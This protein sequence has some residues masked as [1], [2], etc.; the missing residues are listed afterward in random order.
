MLLRFRSKRGT[1]RVECLETELF[2]DVLQRWS[3]QNKVTVDLGLISIAKMDNPTEYIQAG[4]VADQTVSSLSLKHGDMLFL[5]YQELESSSEGSTEITQGSVS[6]KNAGTS[7]SK[8]VM[9]L[10]VDQEIEK[11][12]G[13]IPRSRS[14]FCKHGDKGMCEY[15]SPLPPWDRTYKQENNIKHIAFH[16]H[17]KELNEI[18]NKKSSGSSYIPPLSQPDFKVRNN[19]PSAHAPW[20]KGIC[21]KCQP[22][23]ITLQVQEFRMV[24]HVEFQKG[25]LINEFIESWRSTGLQRFGYLYGSYTHYDNTPLGIKAVIEAIW[26]PPQSNEQDGLTFDVE[27]V[28]KEL[29]HV[30]ALAEEFGLMQIGMIFTDLTDAGNGD[31]S[32]FCKRHKNSFFLSSL[33]VIMAAKQQLKHANPSRFSQQGYFSSK[34]VTCV[35]SGNLKGEIDVSAYQVSTDAEA[36]VDADM[37]SGSTHPSMAYINDTT[38]VRYVPEI[39]YMRK[40]EYNITVKENAKP[41]FPVDYLIVSL[42]HGFPLHD[43]NSS[44]IFS[45]TSGFPW[46][47]RQSMG[48]SQDY[49]EL[50]RYLFAI[51]TGN[52]INLLQS[53]LSNFHML[54][55]VSTLQVL[56]PQEWKLLV[57]A[58]TGPQEHRQEALLELTS[59]P[60]WQT[61]L[62]IMQETV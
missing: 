28:E 26:E 18:T 29:Q 62:M 55:Y 37:I 40:N 12:D 52:D 41:A 45:T 8:T 13:L 57:K 53:K 32:V 5:R 9:E 16:S 21:S 7:P 50:K 27:T 30:N 42:T 34:F 31:G 22:S 38:A 44:P 48:L 35:I 19:C 2:R 11:M 1:S 6:F 3:Q 60:G 20:P 17:V 10:P 49:Y 56:N 14:K 51:A 36:L 59:T 4:N 46:S 33:E 25:E 15:C 39:F 24:D 47:N 54:L 43:D 61:L 58:A 23:A